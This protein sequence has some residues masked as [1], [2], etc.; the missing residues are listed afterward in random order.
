MIN[1]RGDDMKFALI[2]KDNEKKIISATEVLNNMSFYKNCEFIDPEEEFKV[3]F[4]KNCKGHYGPYFRLYLSRSDYLKLSPERK[5]RYDILCKQRHYQESKWHRDWEQKLEPYGKIE[6]YVKSDINNKYKR[7]DFYYEKGKCCV[8][9]QHSY[10]ANDF[11]NRNEFYSNNGLNII[12]LYDLTNMSVKNCYDGYFEILENNAKGFF[13]IAEKESNLTE[14]PVF[15]QVKGNLIYRVK[16]LLRK[17]IDNG[18][19]S[20]IRIFKNSGVYTEDEFITKIL[21]S[22]SEFKAKY[23]L[24]NELKNIHELWDKDFSLMIV[25]DGEKEIKITGLKNGE[26]FRDYDGNIFYNYV[27]WFQTSNTFRERS[28]TNYRMK[29][30]DEYSKKWKLLRAY[31]R[32]NS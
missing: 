24:K 3:I 29:R 28:K 5:D 22:D 14:Y 17:D 32:K 26:I 31:Y 2:F 9:F 30:F 10:I 1:F 12:W 27:D 23:F 16:Q 13:R 7:S 21:N 20:T 6:H 15:I 4:V 11:E 25:T 19:N 8:E 18:L